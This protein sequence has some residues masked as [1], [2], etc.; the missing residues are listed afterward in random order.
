ML[1]HAICIS[2]ILGLIPL[3]CATKNKKTDNYQEIISAW[4]GRNLEELI[5]KAGYPHKSFIASNGNKV[6]VYSFVRSKHKTDYCNTFFETD[7]NGI[8][9]KCSYKGNAC[10]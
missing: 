8:I 1:K 9:V 10:K 3:S 7:S 6:Y 4:N 2:V 5:N